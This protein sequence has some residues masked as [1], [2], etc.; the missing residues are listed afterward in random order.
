MHSSLF[1][2]GHSYNMISTW[3]TLKIHLEVSPQLNRWW[4]TCPWGWIGGVVCCLLAFLPTWKWKLDPSHSSYLSN[5][6]SWITKNHDDGRKRFRG[7]KSWGWS[8]GWF[9]D[10]NKTLTGSCPKVFLW[11]ETMRTEVFCNTLESDIL[12]SPM[13]VGVCWWA[14]ALFE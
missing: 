9:F 6:A 10:K 7:W 1:F 14:C 4:A 3:D 5:T 11:G 8:L 2:G 12:C 13:Y